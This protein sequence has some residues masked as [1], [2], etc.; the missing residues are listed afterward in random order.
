VYLY[1][2]KSAYLEIS[3]S[4]LELNQLQLKQKSL[5]SGKRINVL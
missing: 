5:R 2:G 4:L 1:I 3:E